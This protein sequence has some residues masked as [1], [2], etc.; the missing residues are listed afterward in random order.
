[1]NTR[2]LR[3]YWL[4]VPLALAAYIVGMASVGAKENDPQGPKAYASPNGNAWGFDH[5][6]GKPDGKRPTP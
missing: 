3:L 4:I 6:K 2:T 5:G 1:M